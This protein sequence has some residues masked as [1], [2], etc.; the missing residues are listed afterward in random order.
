MC[1][2]ETWLTGQSVDA[3][4]DWRLRLRESWAI[5]PLASSEILHPTHCLPTYILGSLICTI[6]TGHSPGDTGQNHLFL[7]PRSVTRSA[8]FKAD[9][10][11]SKAALQDHIAALESQLAEARRQLKDSDGLNKADSSNPRRAN[12]I[13]E[14]ESGKSPCR[15]TKCTLHRQLAS[16]LTQ[17]KINIK[18]VLPISRPC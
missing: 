9:S 11:N 14:H 13:H 17:T 1:Q 7:Q 8:Q 4:F 2:E 16:S 10:M 12:G 6:D 15:R 18:A 5:A 3:L